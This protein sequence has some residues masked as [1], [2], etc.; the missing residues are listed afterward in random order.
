MLLANAIPMDK[1][2]CLRCGHSWF[3]RRPE[4]PTL[5]PKCGNAKW[6]QP[7]RGTPDA[8]RVSTHQTTGDDPRETPGLLAAQTVRFGG[9]IA[10]DAARLAELLRNGAGLAAKL[11]DC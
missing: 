11:R 7:A 5:C 10:Q 6:D 9:K 1:V 3:P 2:K 4:R 8:T